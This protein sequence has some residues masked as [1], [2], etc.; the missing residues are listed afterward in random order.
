[1]ICIICHTDK[2]DNSFESTKYGHRK[3]CRSC[4]RKNKRSKNLFEH[5]RRDR[6]YCSKRR[7]E[8]PIAYL[9]ID[10]N[11]TD[12][13]MGFQK[14][15]LTI[16]NVNYLIQDGCKYCGEKSIKMTLDR[17]DNSL[18]HNI[19]NVIP[20]CLRCNIIR[21]SMPYEAW[22]IIANSVKVV[23]NLGLFGDWMPNKKV[24]RKVS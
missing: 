22:L 16:K 2:N 5:R 18:S 1:M 11:S 4:R 15:N 3:T 9:L 8:N 13:K 7:K 14:N 20:S 10:C 6:E 17:I 12:R 21:G 23:N 19:E 24:V